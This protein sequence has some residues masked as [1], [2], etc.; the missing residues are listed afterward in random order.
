MIEAGEKAPDFRLAADDG[1]NFCLKD[2]KG[3]GVLLSFYPKDNT[4]A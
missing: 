1:R 4:S 3:M 2:V